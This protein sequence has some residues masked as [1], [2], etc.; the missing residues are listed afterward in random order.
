VFI[1]PVE[2]YQAFAQLFHLTSIRS[3]EKMKIT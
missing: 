3:V 1:K 2:S